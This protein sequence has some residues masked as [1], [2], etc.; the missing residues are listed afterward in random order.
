MGATLFVRH[1]SGDAT[2]LSTPDGP[3]LCYPKL[4][5][6]IHFIISSGSGVNRKVA[7]SLGSLTSKVAPHVPKPFKSIVKI[8]IMICG[9]KRIFMFLLLST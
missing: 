3:N 9:E 6:L 8:Q 1:P 5:L 7:S 2:F 4:K